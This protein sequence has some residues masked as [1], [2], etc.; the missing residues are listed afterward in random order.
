MIERSGKAASLNSW[1]FSYAKLQGNE[2]WFFETKGVGRP[3][4]STSIGHRFSIYAKAGTWKNGDFV[5]SSQTKELPWDE[6]KAME[7]ALM[8]GFHGYRVSWKMP[9]LTGPEEIATVPDF[10]GGPIEFFC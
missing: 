5:E 10:T 9:I 6:S 4:S 2:T 8:L 7:G 1:W 3:D